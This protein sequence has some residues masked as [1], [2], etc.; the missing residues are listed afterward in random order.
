MLITANAVTNK[1]G[2][3]EKNVRY[4]GTVTVKDSERETSRDFSF[5]VVVSREMKNVEGQL[6]HAVTFHT[7]T[8]KQG[9]EVFLHQEDASKQPEGLDNK[10]I[11]L[12]Q[13]LF[14]AM[15]EGIEAIDKGRMYL[16]QVLWG[17]VCEENSSRHSKTLSIRTA[18]DPAAQRLMREAIYA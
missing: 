6:R 3:G 12:C 16:E 17:V 7:V 15:E 4:A 1:L 13:M 2:T 10:R 11:L 14:Q 8:I 5:Q 18:S 9:K